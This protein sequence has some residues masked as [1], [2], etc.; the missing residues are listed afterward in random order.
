VSAVRV[1]LYSGN[2]AET[3]SHYFMKTLTGVLFIGGI[4]L[5]SNWSL[6]DASATR[7][8]PQ[9]P[10][11][12]PRPTVY[13]S[14]LQIDALPPSGATVQKPQ[15]DPHEL[16]NHVV[17]LMSTKLIAALQKAG[18]PAIRMRAGDARPDSGV[19]IR[20]LFAEVDSENHW[21]RAVIRTASDNGRMQAL[22]GVANLAKPDQALYE[23]AP[24]PGNEDKPGAVI[25]LSPYV[26]LTKYE[27]SKDASEDVF[28]GIAVRVVNDLTELLQ[29][30]PFA[31]P[32]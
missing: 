27:L 13:V 17:K 8:G 11:S 31:I 10:S 9:T 6:G 3:G 24:L 1:F 32:Q 30:N 7:T 18:Y 26:P 21:R 14:D 16:A 20:G 22:V 29:R 15:D 23:I 4:L 2:A 19:Q 28:K 25:T 5:S 12:E